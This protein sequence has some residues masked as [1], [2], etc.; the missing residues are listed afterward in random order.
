MYEIPTTIELDGIEFN[1]RNRGDYRTILD[2]FAALEDAELDKQERLFASL[3]IFYE[4][5]E[6][7]EDINKLG[8]IELAVKEMY[9]FFNCGSDGSNGRKVPYKLM[10]WKQDEQLIA[11]AVNKVAGTEIRSA[12][13]IHWWT[14]V[15]Y[16]SA[17]GECPLASILSI[18]D[19]IVKGKQLE[20][21]ER[22]FR[23]DN[24]QYFIWNKNTVEEEEADRLVRE[25]W[26][27]GD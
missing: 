14:F 4:D 20:K 11:S 8:N 3:I 9:K 19:K 25:L 1:I 15:G 7:I 17:I 6:S 13:Y 23:Q 24:P 22:A 16:Y 2:C 27:S 10:D 12:K 18:R 5:L 26:N 21:N